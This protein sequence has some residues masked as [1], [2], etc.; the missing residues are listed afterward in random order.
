MER[1]HAPIGTSKVERKNVLIGISSGMTIIKELLRLVAV[2]FGVVTLSFCLQLFTGT[3]PAEMIVRKQNIFATEAQIQAVR[4]ELKLDAPF[5]VRYL[6]YLG[7]VARGDL[8]TAIMNRRPVAEN[9]R[10][11]L[12]VTTMLILLSM[13][14]VV[15]FSIVVAA[16]AVLRKDRAF[17][18]VTRIIC[19]IGIC[20]PSFWLGLILLAVFAV[21][22]PIFQ[23]IA[24]GSLKS[25]ILP[26]IAMAFPIICISIRVLRASVLN[27]LNSDYVTYARARGFTNGQIIYG[28][29]LK[30]ALP[31]AITLFAQYCAALFGTS[32]LVESVFSIRGLGIYLMESCE[33][34]DVY[35]ISGAIL[36]CAVLFVLF[37]IA[38]DLLSSAVCPAY[39][40]KRI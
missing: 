9:I 24:D 27:E 37:N 40:R 17:D 18:N 38:A 21:R 30:N 23:V 14:W 31:P 39:G 3:D 5:Q 10:E 15:L 16:A 25:F 36:V 35:G 34:M 2:I 11:V 33:S 28:E 26:S 13:L 1:K 4:E 19:I 32:A 12:P 8:G 29:V 20:V 22:I 7:G 6:D